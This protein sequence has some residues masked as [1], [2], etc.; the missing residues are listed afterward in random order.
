M[1]PQLKNLNTEVVLKKNEFE[2]ACKI[3]PIR[4]YKLQYVL[5]MLILL[6]TLFLSSCTSLELGVHYSKMAYN[7]CSDLDNWQ[8]LWYDY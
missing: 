8:C 6:S 7:K 4:S 5:I 3:E 1:K 2:E